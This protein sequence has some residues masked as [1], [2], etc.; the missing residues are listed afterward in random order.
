LALSLEDTNH[1]SWNCI[2]QKFGLK[3]KNV[4]YL[5]VKDKICIRTAKVD[6]SKLILYLYLNTNQSLHHLHL[7]LHH[8]QPGEVQDHEQDEHN[9]CQDPS[10]WHY[11]VLEQL[12]HD[13]NR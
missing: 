7:R 1:K 5:N 4:Y 10:G 3:F 12:G 13:L 11:S 2:I 8:Q 6:K 9:H